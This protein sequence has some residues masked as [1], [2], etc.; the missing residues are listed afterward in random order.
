MIAKKEINKRLLEIISEV[1]NAQS[2]KSYP[3]YTDVLSDTEDEIKNNEFKITVVGEFSSG[4]STFLNAII[5]KDVLPHGVKETTATITYI[6]NVP[7]SD[8]LCN[9]AIIH[10]SDKSLE[11]QT[12][13]IGNDRNALVDYVTTSEKQYH[14]VKDIVSVDIYVHFADIEEP[15]VLI[16]T[17][18]MNGVADGHRDITLH[19]IR[20]SHASICLFHIRGIGQ[21]DLDFIKEL[22]KYQQTV[23][24]VL[25]A[26]DDIRLEEETYEE[27]MQKFNEDIT[28]YVYDDKQKPEYVFGISALKALVARDNEIK[29]LYD[30]DERDLTDQDRARI[31]KESM[32]L[33][34][35]ASLFNFLNNSDKERIFYLSLCKRILQLLESF[36][37][38]ADTDKNIREVKNDNIPEKK[39]IQELISKAEKTS[40]EFRDK[41][42]TTLTSMIEDLRNEIYKMI[43]ED[44]GNEY[45]DRV[46][47][48]NSIATIE[49]AIKMT[50]NNIIGKKLNNFWNRQKIMLTDSMRK[51]LEDIQR[52]IVIEMQQVIPI[53]TFKDKQ[54]GL[55][56][57]PQFE[58]FDDSSFQSRLRQLRSKKESLERDIKRAQ[59]GPS[60]AEL[61]RKKVE[62]ETEQTQLQNAYRAKLRRLGS[63]PSVQYKTIEHKTKKT[64]WFWKPWQWG[65]DRY[66]ITYETVSDD[67]ARRRYDAEKNRIEREYSSTLREKQN[68]LQQMESKVLEAY[69][70]EQMRKLWRSQADTIA[71]KIKE[72][73]MAMQSAMNNSRTSYLKKIKKDYLGKIESLLSCPSG[74][75]YADLTD[76][77][78]E[79]LQKSKEP[80][81]QELIKIFDAKKK[82]YIDKLQQM[83]S[84]IEGSENIADN[85][86]Q[87]KILSTDITIID[88]NINNLNHII[89]G[90][91]IKL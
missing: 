9:K 18:G 66:D 81:L 31:L 36:K 2:I 23:F 88:N 19:E 64:N 62:I 8:A 17:P 61:E 37:T 75:M 77:V 34:F 3:I 10:F 7:T 39:K 69:N 85:I 6:H 68:L 13:D 83:I 63:R 87:I 26:I 30:T 67:S 71:L 55:D 16:D 79:S 11:N 43:R 90:L 86:Q 42:N 15:I 46:A 57:N 1:K 84:R 25:N 89:Y 60:S 91:Q 24:F 48:I 73:E 28:K 74:Q 58:E 27:R 4:K 47:E 32:M 35:E 12:L 72:E 20:H 50:D 45:H 14:V 49:D 70:N 44:I 41:L 22:M 40:L 78:R 59:D 65:S 21:S 76:G 80:M 52:S 82:A 33:D 53:I 38:A 56:T 54:F 51:G 5:G 29:R